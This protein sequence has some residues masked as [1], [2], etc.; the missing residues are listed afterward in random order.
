MITVTREHYER[1]KN[2]RVVFFGSNGGEW[3]DEEL[4]SHAVEAAIVAAGMEIEK[5]SAAGKPVASFTP[6]QFK[7]V[8]QQAAWAY[9]KVYVDY[10]PF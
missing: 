8:I 6:E 10:I 3:S 5:S 7:C 1:L 9:M 2:Q 4:E